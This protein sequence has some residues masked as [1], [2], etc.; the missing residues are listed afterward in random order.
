MH[1]WY[2]YVEGFAARCVRDTL[3]RG[4][5][6]PS[7]VYDPFGGAGT[8]QLTAS[9]MQI[10]A[11]YAEVN[12]FM[13]FVAETKVNR[14]AWGR[15][16]LATVRK[17]FARFLEQL[18]ASTLDRLGTQVDLASYATAFPGRDFFVERNL[19]NLLAARNLAD[20]VSGKEHRV[21]DLLRLA[22]AANVVR[23]SNMTRRADLRRRR[24]DEYKGRLVNVAAFIRESV[25]RMLDDI[26]QLPLNMA[27][28]ARVADDSRQLGA[29]WQGRFDMVITSPPYLNGTNYIRNTELELWYLGYLDSEA[30]LADYR[31]QTVCAGINDV[32]RARD[33]YTHFERVE[34]VA[35]QL[36]HQTKDRRIPI[37]VRHYFS[38]MGQVFRGTFG[39]LVPGGRIILDIGDSQFYGVHVPTDELL[40][41]AAQSVGF[42]VEHK[43]LLA[44]RY[45]R[46]NVELKQFELVLR[47]PKGSRIVALTRPEQTTI[48]SSIEQFVKELPFKSEPYVSR[49]WGHPLHSLC[50]YQGKMKPG[51]AYWLI[52]TFVR[53][54]S[55]VLDPL[56]GV[57]TIPFEAALAGHRAVSNDK[58]PF[59]SVIAAAKL[60]PPKLIHVLDTLER[61]SAAGSRQQP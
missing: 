17:V 27:T 58:S 18:D 41:D 30:Q 26:E 20:Q 35:K 24:P 42:E 9:M 43:H 1:S 28:M 52:H 5:S 13:V 49:N 14:S 50:S 29:D 7:N 57:G 25:E 61:V 2:P 40:L 51:L 22:C 32:S 6:P 60:N 23:S 31:R 56:G 38:D 4:G 8:T 12:P 10:P 19:R 39:A 45:S 46:N 36:D 15:N 16:N 37:M 44:R 59:A 11:F 33:H 21:R 54:N 55:S 47:K 48:E 53:P 3:L 34:E